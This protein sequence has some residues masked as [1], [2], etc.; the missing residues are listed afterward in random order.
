MD[1]LSLRNSFKNKNITMKHLFRHSY[2]LILGVL[3]AVLS[4]CGCGDDDISGSLKNVKLQLVKMVDS[5]TGEIVIPDPEYDH[6]GDPCFYMIIEA[7]ETAHI[8][9]EGDL[10]V[11]TRNLK[12]REKKMCTFI[13]YNFSGN[14]Y[15]FHSKL[16]SP[17]KGYEIDKEGLKYYCKN[18]KTYLLFNLT[19]K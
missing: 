1:C 14:G 6:N 17:Y 2:P 3:L 9:I 11:Y 13:G 4:L 8:H 10:F 12:K 16:C 18:K 5:E 15:E 7:D 19:E